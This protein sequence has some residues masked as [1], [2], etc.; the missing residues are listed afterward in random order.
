MSMKIKE[1]LKSL[2]KEQEASFEPGEGEQMVNAKSFVGGKKKKK[3][4]NEEPQKT[5][6]D[7]LKQGYNDGYA[8]AKANKVNKF[9][10]K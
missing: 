6:A 9:L 5:W 3:A 10:N 7:G 4:V 8:D 1:I 2:V